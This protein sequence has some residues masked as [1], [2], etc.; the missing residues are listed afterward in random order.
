MDLLTRDD[1]VEIANP[2][3]GGT[4]VSLFL[5]TSRSGREIEAD[6][7]R[8]K[9]MLSDVE[10]ALLDELRRPDVEKLLAPARELLDDAIEW[11]Y[12]SDGLVMYLGPDGH[13]AYR[14]PAPITPL[15]T[16]GD[17]RVLAHLLRLLSGDEH[18][19]LLALSQHEVRLLGGS[20]NAV[21]E[22]ELAEIPTS[23]ADVARGDD[24]RTDAVARPMGRRGGRAV[25]YGHSGSDP[26]LRQQETERLLRAVAD[27]MRDV[28]RGQSAPLVL[29]GLEHL[30]VTYRELNDYPHLMSEAVPHNADGLSA[31][32]LH[33]LAWPLVE[34]RL[35]SA[36]DEVI[37]RFRELHGTGRVSS[38][39]EAVARAATEGRVETLFVRADPWSWEV[40][41]DDEIPVVRLGKDERYALS[42]L[43]DA[44]AVATIST[45]GQVF[46]TSRV[47]V[48]DSQVAAIYRY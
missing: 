31:E 15:A 36:R 4:Y 16:I 7:L 43:V 29:V 35:Q 24:S 5:P 46:A 18:F 23:L 10:S 34:R 26:N 40:A 28:L 30:V 48:P 22:I 39:L 25:F 6:R 13:R 3:T 8:W 11:Q 27:G 2:E 17:H 44:A 12:M 41:S 19:H 32:E 21:E 47:V 38:D 14:V 45:G 9:N 37:G 33:R 1:L 42:E 20:R